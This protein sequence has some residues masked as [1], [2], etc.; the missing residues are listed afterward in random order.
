[1]ASNINDTITVKAKHEL[2]QISPLFGAIPDSPRASI[3]VVF[4]ILF[5]P[6]GGT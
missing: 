1:M 2:N 5:G 3:F 6:G 4:S